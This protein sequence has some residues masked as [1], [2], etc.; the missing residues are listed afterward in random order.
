MEQDKL[1]ALLARF[2]GEPGVTQGLTQEEMIA[3]LQALIDNGRIYTMDSGILAHAEVY[4]EHGW[5]TGFDPSK[6]NSGDRDLLK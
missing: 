1:D 4:A 5:L 2:Q 6:A 3:M